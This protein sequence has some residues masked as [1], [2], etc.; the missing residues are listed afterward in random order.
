MSDSSSS[1]SSAK[2]LNNLSNESTAVASPSVQVAATPS[3]PPTAPTT[4]TTA[5]PTTPSTTSTGTSSE[6]PIREDMVKSAV[7]FLS[8]P[9]VRSAD[10]AKK[11]AFLR[12]KGLNQSEIDEAFK[13]AG[14]S[15]LA[16]SSPPPTTTNTTT[17]TAAATVSPS[18]NHVSTLFAVLPQAFTRPCEFS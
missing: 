12:N 17:T 9:N 7:S 15:G 4:T 2:D 16:A 10:K 13:R 3:P 5:A 8:A 14:D 11:I 18:V 6:N 1:S